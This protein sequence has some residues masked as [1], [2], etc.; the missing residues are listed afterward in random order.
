MRENK[1]AIKRHV[2]QKLFLTRPR[3]RADIFEQVVIE[4]IER[5][6]SRLLKGAGESREHLDVTL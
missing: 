2:T 1:R 5:L 3:I 4:K 6:I